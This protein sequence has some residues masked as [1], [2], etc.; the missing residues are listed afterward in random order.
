MLF[1]ALAPGPA[2]DGLRALAD[3]LAR[4]LAAEGLV[5]DGE[6]APVTPHVTLAKVSRDRDGSALAEANRHSGRSPAL[7]RLRDHI[8]ELG[9]GQF[10]GDEQIDRVELLAMARADSNESFYHREASL[11]LEPRALVEPAAALERVVLH[12]A[13]AD[14]PVARPPTRMSRFVDARGVPIGMR[15]R[16]PKRSTL[17]HPFRVGA[18]RRRR[19]PGALLAAPEERA[20]IANEWMFAYGAAFLVRP[21]LPPGQR[22]ADIAESV[23]ASVSGWRLAFNAEGGRENLIRASSPSRGTPAHG[24]A[25]RLTRTQLDCAVAAAREAKYGPIFIEGSARAYDGRVLTSVTAFVAARVLCGSQTPLWDG[26]HALVSSRSSWQ[27]AETL[28]PRLFVIALRKAAAACGLDQTYLAQLDAIPTCEMRDRTPAY[29]QLERNHAL[30]DS[31]AG[32]VPKAEALTVS[33]GE[34]KARESRRR[35]R[36]QHAWVGS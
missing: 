23:A 22:S 21:P 28:H 30:L 12:D 10:Y 13:E 4:A 19:S 26:T 6:R 1:A 25:F 29:F 36:L 7:A 8:A 18:A 15:S 33:A 2:L 9:E 3:G 16:P 27:G 34:R 35:G 24:V 31:C 14:A 11:T 32:G 20:E 5:T 17:G